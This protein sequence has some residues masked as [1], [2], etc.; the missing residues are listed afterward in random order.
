MKNVATEK[1]KFIKHVISVISLLEMKLNCNGF[2][3]FNDQ[4]RIMYDN[5][6]IL[7]E[8]KNYNH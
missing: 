6:K 3:D 2:S 1:T 5:Q 4:I 8:K 7:T